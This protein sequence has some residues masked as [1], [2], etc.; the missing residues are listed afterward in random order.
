MAK[1]KISKEQYDESVRMFN[2][3]LSIREIERQLGIS[4]Q[5]ISRNLKKLGIEIISHKP[6][7]SYENAA[8][9][10][11]NSGKILSEFCK[12]HK[13]SKKWFGEYLI[14]ND[15][16]YNISPK[17]MLK[18]NENVFDV[19]DTEEKAYW[20]GFIYADGYIQYTPDDKKQEY[21]FELSLG[22]KDFE[23]LVKFNTFMEHINE[24][25]IKTDSY[26]CRFIISN[27]HLWHTLNNY[28]CTPRKSLTLEFPDESIFKSEDLIRHFIRGYFDGDG[29][30]SWGNSEHTKPN[31]SCLGTEQFL[32]KLQE[33]LPLNRDKYA[34]S[35]NN[36][37]QSLITKV[38]SFAGNSAIDFALYLYKD[39]NIYLDRKYEIYKIY[40]NCRSER[41]LSG[42]LLDNIGE[43]WNVN[44]EINSEIAK[45]SESS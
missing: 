29:C 10:Y 8:I 18:F 7:I 37:E 33:Y 14:K 12:E 32:N 25:H 38:L 11:T 41:G 13:M 31:A 34:L 44:T 28:G 39:S 27:K 30:L 6:T 40:L 36:K 16:P 21:D 9:L 45:G 19:I 1:N 20:L 3:G 22:L 4:Q 42:L 26:R 23:H 17:M 2:S 5:S 24:N 35:Y 15:I 43:D